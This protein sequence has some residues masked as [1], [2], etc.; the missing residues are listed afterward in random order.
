M[1]SGLSSVK[2]R[3]KRKKTKMSEHPRLLIQKLS[4]SARLPS[5]AYDAGAYDLYCDSIARQEQNGS[6]VIGTGLAIAIPDGYVGLIF[7][8]SS[9]G[10]KH[11]VRPSNC[12]GVI[13]ADYRGEIKIKLTSDS[14]IGDDYLASVNPS[15][16]DPIAQMLIIAKP[17]FEMEVVDQLP[18]SLRGTGG[19]GS[20]NKQ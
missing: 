8:R 19:F 1:A 10:F 7:G 11:D 18:E 3:T 12:V 20:S 14:F 17:Q 5:Q 16:V 15:T 4:E 6:V 13:D 2:P 9:Q